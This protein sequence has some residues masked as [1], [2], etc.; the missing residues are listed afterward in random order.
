MSTQKIFRGSSRWSIRRRLNRDISKIRQSSNSARFSR[1]NNVA[2]E[3]Q[4]DRLGV[5]NNS[6]EC[7]SALSSEGED[8]LPAENGNVGAGFC[9]YDS[10]SEI[11]RFSDTDSESELDFQVLK[12]KNKNA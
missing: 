4:N 11:N 5:K 6:P 12:A 10:E 2:P 9:D 7:L 1:P 8:I 3:I